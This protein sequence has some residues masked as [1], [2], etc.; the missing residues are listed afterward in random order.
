MVDQP[1]KG[2]GAGAGT[3]WVDGVASWTVPLPIEAPDGEVAL[4]RQEA[5]SLTARLYEME[6]ETGRPVQRIRQV[7]YEIVYGQPV[8]GT[9]YPPPPPVLEH[10]EIREQLTEEPELARLRLNT[11][12]LRYPDHPV[13]VHFLVKVHRVLGDQAT[14]DRLAEQNHGRHPRYLFARL[15]LAQVYLA[16]NQLDRIPA[17]FDGKFSLPQVCPGRTVFHVSEHLGFS[18]V[19]AEYFLARNQPNLAEA[20]LRNI[21]EVDPEHPL[22]QPQTIAGVSFLARLKRAAHR[23]TVGGERARTGTDDRG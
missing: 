23:W 18:S 11:W 6:E 21:R 22:A 15:D 9:D 5:E 14:A 4:T 3:V 12:L 17:L 2:P 7:T 1:G 13:L 8:P 19:M 16:R 20:Y 10:P